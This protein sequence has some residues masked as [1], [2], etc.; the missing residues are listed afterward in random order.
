MVGVMTAGPA[1]AAVDTSISWN[2]AAG[3]A[4]VPGRHA[5]KLLGGGDRYEAYV[6]WD[7]RLH[8]PVVAKLL[9]PH[10]VEDAR[11]RRA[12]DAEAVALERLQHPVLVRSFGAVLHG[13]RPH[14]ILE[15]IEGPRLST[16]LRR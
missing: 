13:N 4:I 14:L 16:L 1:A 3:E 10:L 6:A 12:I 9:R 7:D 11:S 5:L 15:H 2:F 8:V